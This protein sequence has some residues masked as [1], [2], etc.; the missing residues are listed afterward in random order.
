MLDGIIKIK[1]PS[2]IK[3]R[4]IEN[5]KRNNSSNIKDDNIENKKE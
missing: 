5:K 1:I 3:D 2:N 4:N